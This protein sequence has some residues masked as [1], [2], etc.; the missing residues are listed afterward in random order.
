MPGVEAQT[1]AEGATNRPAR[2]LSAD[3]VSFTRHSSRRYNQARTSFQDLF[4]DLYSYGLAL[5][6][7]GAVAVS[8]VVSVKDAITSRGAVGSVH[9]SAHWPSIPAPALWTLIVYAALTAVL[10]LAGRMGPIMVSG[11]EGQW[12]LPLPVDRRPMVLP[13]FL[14]RSILS[15]FGAAAAFLP[16]SVFTSGH[17]TFPEHLLGSST[18]GAVT[19]VAVALAG[20]VQLGVV[21]PRLRRLAAAVALIPCAVLP[22]LTG[23]LWAP[24]LATL[25]AALLLGVVASRAGQV[26]GADLIRG[27]AVAGHAQ[28]SLFFMDTN[29]LLRAFQGARRIGSARRGAGFYSRPA[30]G[31][32][33]ALVRADTAAFLR[34]QPSAALPLSWLG[35]IIATLLVDHGV[36]A[37]AQIGVIAIAGCAVSSSAGTV[38]RQAALVPGLDS[39]LPISPPWGRA[40]RTFMPALAMSLWMTCLTGILMLLGVAGPA[41]IL[42][43]ALSGIGM[44]AGAVRG[45]TRPVS[46]WSVPPVE[47]PFGPI[48]QAQIGSL[49]RGLD[50]TVLA[51]TPVL[52][53]IYTGDAH[54]AAL[55][56]QCLISAG[57]LGA[58][59]L[60][61]P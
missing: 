48:P 34:L 47:T 50:F 40:S 43:G 45:A 4:T 16:F 36:P 24:T 27:G 31:P 6:C 56:I 59:V 33:S 46:D 42:L 2:D 44:G 19:V 17:R 26:R 9:I 60:R 35:V 52:A 54:P 11:P 53:S 8:V 37:L 32:V 25:S 30:R 57:T 38:A 14:R 51:L 20:F 21:S 58:V 3:I 13:P 22:S 18:I 29:E 1:L 39:L 15:G 49:L 23:S 55:I 41:L 7:A 12:W 5:G 10:V 28:S 61:S